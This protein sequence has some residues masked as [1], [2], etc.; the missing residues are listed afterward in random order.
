MEAQLLHNIFLFVVSS[1][2]AGVAEAASEDCG[3]PP[4]AHSGSSARRSRGISLRACVQRKRPPHH[5]SHFVDRS[6]L[7][8]H[9]CHFKIMFQH[10]ACLHHVKNLQLSICTTAVSLYS[11]FND[12][13]LKHPHKLVFQ[14]LGCNGA[15]S[16]CIMVFPL[17]WP[18]HGNHGRYPTP[19]R[20][21]G[22]GN[23]NRA[24][25]VGQTGNIWIL[26]EL[27]F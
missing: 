18:Q 12:E 17:L 3:P 26:I 20:L 8:C 9:I 11:V 14:P 1:G 15:T 6:T 2:A 5:Q 4:T 19:R 27:H 24:S 23:I 7:L 16:W 25:S 10:A 21:C 22:L 13:S